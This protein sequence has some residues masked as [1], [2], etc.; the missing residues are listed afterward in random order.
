MSK[1]RRDISR[2]TSAG[3]KECSSHFATP[4]ER[5]ACKAGVMIEAMR[6]MVDIPYDQAKGA[7]RIIKR[8]INGRPAREACE[9]G[10]LLYYP[11]T[12]KGPGL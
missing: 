12:K 7:C 8:N 6:K 4:Q 9:Q 3:L 10:M 5:K 2:R 11:R 1:K